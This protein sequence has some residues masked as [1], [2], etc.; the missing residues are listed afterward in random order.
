M[1][2]KNSC[3]LKDCKSSRTNMWHWFWGAYGMSELI[4]PLLKIWCFFFHFCLVLNLY[5]SLPRF[6][7]VHN[8]LSLYGWWDSSSKTRK[9]THLA[10]NPK[11][12]KK[13]GRK[14]AGS[15]SEKWKKMRLKGQ[16]ST[17][18][19]ISTYLFQLSP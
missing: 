12:K 18:F 2:D 3:C 4:L 8:L 17:N 9:N 13:K 5:V 7:Y 1:D 19:Q 15:E 16:N 10:R 6:I 11:K 14:V